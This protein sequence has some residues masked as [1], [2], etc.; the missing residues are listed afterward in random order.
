[1]LSRK[2][3]PFVAMVATLAAAIL[4]TVSGNAG[5][6]STAL[7]FTCAGKS[8]S[9]TFNMEP[10]ETTL[11]GG[12][13]FDYTWSTSIN[14][15]P[16]QEYAITRAT[17]AMQ[18]SGGTF[19]DAPASIGMTPPTG[20]APTIAVT[21]TGVTLDLPGGLPHYDAQNAPTANI[22]ATFQ[23]KA[24]NSSGNM[25]ISLTAMS[26]EVEGLAVRCTLATA[27]GVIHTNTVEAGSDPVDPGP[28]ADPSNPGEQASTTTSS[29]GTTTTTVA[30]GDEM[31]GS[32]SPVPTGKSRGRATEAEDLSKQKTTTSSS[33][34]SSSTTSTSLSSSAP[35]TTTLVN[36]IPSTVLTTTSLAASTTSASTTTPTTSPPPTPRAESRSGAASAVVARPAFTG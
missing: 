6:V 16:L 14:L 23:G 30:N 33:S 19:T 4:W 29:I 32:L 36:S 24:A 22:G 21:S 25:T 26:F 35:T 15:E 8:I 10:G 12:E 34:T 31:Q 11:A 28:T 18:I 13:T 9:L 1:M 5:A 17:L 7:N 3:K 20:S 2:A 27:P